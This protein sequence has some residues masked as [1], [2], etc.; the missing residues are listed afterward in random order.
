M[1]RRHAPSPGR[2]LTKATVDAQRASR[3]GRGE[4][5]RNGLTGAASIP[6]GRGGQRAAGHGPGFL[7]CRRQRVFIPLHVLEQRVLHASGQ[8]KRFRDLRAQDVRRVLPIRGRREH[9]EGRDAGA[10]HRAQTGTRP[11]RGRRT[12]V[13]GGQERQGPVHGLAAGIHGVRPLSPSRP[14]LAEFRRA[15]VASTY[16]STMRRNSSAMF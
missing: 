3:H 4:A 15:Y 14:A 9:D 16:P 13:H 8:R 10:Q 1:V 12:P 6:A 2:G 7:Q 5:S 11:A